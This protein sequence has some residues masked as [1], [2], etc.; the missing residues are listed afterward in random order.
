MGPPRQ[1][2]TDPCDWGDATSTSRLRN[3]RASLLPALRARERSLPCWNQPT[4]PHCGLTGFRIRYPRIWHL[5]L[6]S[7]SSWRDLRTSRSRRD[8]LTFLWS[9]SSDPPWE[10]LSMRGTLPTPTPGGKEHPSLQRTTDAKRNL[11]KR[12]GL[13]F[14]QPSTLSSY[15][16]LSYHVFPRPSALHQTCNKNTQL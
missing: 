15:S 16:F 9:R 10:A 8:S 3:R 1:P 11:N 5:G 12:T 6:L 4:L 14:P 2:I 13:V 7:I